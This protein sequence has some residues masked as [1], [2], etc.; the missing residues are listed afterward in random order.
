M[1]PVIV[2]VKEPVPLPSVVWLSAIVGF[3]EVPQQS[4]R[5]VT[6][7][8]LFDVTAPPPETLVEVATSG[9]EVD[10][11]GADAAGIPKTQRSFIMPEVPPLSYPQPPKNQ[12]PLESIHDA[13]E[14]CPP[15]VFDADAIPFEPQTPH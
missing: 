9:V 11:E 6:A 5:A 3:K 15:G 10:T 4:P 13:E 1:R 8:P 12:R 7:G 2:L 14:T